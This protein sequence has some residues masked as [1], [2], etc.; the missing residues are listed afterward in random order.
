MTYAEHLDLQIRF[1]SKVGIRGSDDCWMWKASFGADGYGKFWLNKKWTTAHRAA[2]ELTYFQLVRR[3]LYVCHWCDNHPCC[4]PGHLF[5]ASRTSAA[6]RM[7]LVGNQW[8]RQITHCP[9]G[10]EYTEEN[11]Y[12]HTL[13]NGRKN[14]Y[15]RIC[16]RAG[17]AKSRRRRWRGDF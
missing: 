16:K 6:R 10:H 1:W 7:V 14:R 4:N 3:G 15:C 8:C 13:R 12:L 9:K 11:T 2:W 5:T 17:K